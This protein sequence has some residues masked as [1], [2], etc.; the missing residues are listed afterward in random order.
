MGDVQ[1]MVQTGLSVLWGNVFLFPTHRNLPVD[2]IFASTYK[3]RSLVTELLSV[4][5]F[6]SL[7]VHPVSVPIGTLY[8]HAT[9]CKPQS[10][11]HWGVGEQE[12]P[13]QQAPLQSATRAQQQ[14][15]ST[16]LSL[17]L[18][19]CSVPAATGPSLYLACKRGVFFT[20]EVAGSRLTLYW[21]NATPSAAPA[22]I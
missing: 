7:C 15:Q 17:R 18:E 6:A 9:G 2:V 5:R 1:T 3:A 11:R 4:L 21:H 8:M 10:S 19:R 12:A 22:C 20:K 13:C 16:H 14:Q